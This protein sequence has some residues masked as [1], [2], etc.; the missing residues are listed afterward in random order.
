PTVVTCHV[1]VCPNGARFRYAERALCERSVG[2][3]CVTDGYR[4]GGC[5]TTAD[6]R[7]YGLV[8]FAA[9][10]IYSRWSLRLLGRSAAVIAPS[11]WQ[12]RMLERDGVPARLLQV[13]PP[14]VPGGIVVEHGSRR[15]DRRPIVLL[16]GR[17][18]VLKGFD[19]ALRASAL[20]NTEHEIHIAGSGP[21][22]RGL[23][24]LAAGLDIE[25]RVHFLG[26]LDSDELGRAS[27]AAAVVVVPSLWPETYG[28]VGP[29]ALM[30]G[31]PVVAYL[32][33]GIA[34]WA[35]SASGAVGVATG[36]FEA[37]A[38]EIEQ[39]LLHREAAR[40]P[41]ASR[42]RIRAALD[43]GSHALELGE[44]YDRVTAR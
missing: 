36:D 26:D 29:E 11:V 43:P 6:E 40:P 33:G 17:L 20:I 39:V 8:S 42:L 28:M 32:S 24:D 16:A 10:L 35:S 25:D 3:T 38:G 19:D 7:A 31:T 34:D 2:A 1:P 21:A 30:R 27:A 14:P 22:E 13:L 15:D 4:N 5:A 23:R 41:E 37:M 18:V 44:L 9:G 12:A